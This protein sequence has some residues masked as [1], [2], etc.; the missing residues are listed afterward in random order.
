MTLQIVF[1]LISRVYSFE[2]L[3]G[4]VLWPDSVSKVPG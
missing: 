2:T 3:D 4:R 1:V